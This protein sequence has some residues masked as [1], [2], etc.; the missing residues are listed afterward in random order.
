MFLKE[1]KR[2][3]ETHN[4]IYVLIFHDQREGQ[5]FESPH[6]ETHLFVVKVCAVANKTNSKLFVNCE[7]YYKTNFMVI[8][9]P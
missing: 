6:I 8:Q 3:A 1:K 5:R 7:Q 9:L 2:S 4:S